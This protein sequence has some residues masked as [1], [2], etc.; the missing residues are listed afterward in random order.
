MRLL[1]DHSSH[2]AFG[3]NWASYARIVDEKR[4]CEAESGLLR[5]VGRDC[6]RQR[7]FLDI[8]CGSGLHALV[9]ARLGA[10]QIFAIDIDPTSVET[11]RRL[12]D[13]HIPAADRRVECRSVF[14]LTPNGLGLFDVVY[15]W[16]A[17]HHTGA[18]HEAIERA[19]RMVAPGG[20]FVFAL[21]RRT[22]LCRVWRREKQWYA[23]ASPR[24]QKIAQSVYLGLLRLQFLLTGRDFKTYLVDHKGSRGMD[25]RHDIHDWLGGYPY[26]SIS[27]EEVGSIMHRLGFRHVRSFTGPLRI[28][29]FGSGCDE[30]V[31]A[32][33]GPSAV[34]PQNDIP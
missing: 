19:A 3:D 6:L 12:L 2:F 32:P 17:L 9:A 8:G 28:G 33:L 24:A 11:T 10:S 21:Y 29:F 7:S 22:R 23:N 16:G 18:M 30:Y 20:L 15:S 4:I 5:L 26:E 14:D 13:L 27:A 34:E 25:Y 31:Y 1:K